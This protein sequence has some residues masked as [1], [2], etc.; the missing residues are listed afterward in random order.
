LRL[1]V[2]LTLP[3]AVGLWFLAEPVIALIYQH[4]QFV[5]NDTRQTALALQFYA[6]GLVAY[7]CIKVLSPAFYAI[8]KKWT[9]MT[10]SFGAVGLN[11]ILNY[12][13]MF[14]L[15]LGHKGLALSTSICALLNFGVLY[16]LMRPA[17]LTLES[18]RL[19]GTLVRCS[20]AATALAAVCKVSL[21]HAQTF[22]PGDTLALQATRLFATIG[23]ASAAY[24][25]AC[26]LLRV[27]ETTSVLDILKRKLQRR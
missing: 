12:V 22:L 19:A 7:S 14:H 15:G 5:E 16:L 23:A 3:S 1:A 6:A 24:L 2:F 13:F 11:L 27:E 26:L 9:P 21:D 18:R 17:V 8:D 20:L 4:G 25:I 10:V